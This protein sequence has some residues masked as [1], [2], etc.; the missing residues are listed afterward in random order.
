MRRIF[1]ISLGVFF[2]SFQIQSADK[3][4]R[5]GVVAEQKVADEA[6]LVAL[7]KHQVALLGR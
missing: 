6:D 7:D 2:R 4:L 1:F 5:Y 3:L